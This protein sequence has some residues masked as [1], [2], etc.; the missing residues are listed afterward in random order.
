MEP[1]NISCLVQ[2]GPDGLAAAEI[3]KAVKAALSSVFFHKK[4][5]KRTNIVASRSEGRFVIY[6]TT[7]LCKT[8]SHFSLRTVVVEI[9]VSRQRFAT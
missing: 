2:A 8:S 5:L 9:N 3:C 1:A 4:E 7:S 6:S